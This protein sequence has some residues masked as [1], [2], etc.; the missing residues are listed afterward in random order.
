MLC[1][2]CKEPMVVLE[3]DEIE[4][5]YCTGCDGV[6]LDAGELELMF[7]TDDERK[8]LIETLHEDPEHTEKPYNCPICNKKMIKVHVGDKK[9][10]LIDKCIKDHGLWF[11][12]G[13]LK[14]VIELGS[15]E[16]NKIVNILTEMFEDKITTNDKGEN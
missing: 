4:I 7:E 15:K 13:E 9:E 2:V 16:E 3:L 1:P 11:D 5:D 12:Q 10:I 8:R 6:W 14:S